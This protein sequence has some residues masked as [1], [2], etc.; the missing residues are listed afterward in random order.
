MDE[1]YFMLHP[2]HWV[3]KGDSEQVFR[4]L[5]LSGGDYL[6]SWKNEKDELREVRYLRTEV[7]EAI[8]EVHWN[9][10]EEKVTF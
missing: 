8:A 3:V 10:L 7:L 6:V 4:A 1:F 5:E 2:K 9:V